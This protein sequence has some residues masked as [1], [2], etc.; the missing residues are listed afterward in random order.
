MGTSS[1]E[2]ATP[3]ADGISLC[4]VVVPAT[5]SELTL[6]GKTPAMRPV[7]IGLLTVTPT[8]SPVAEITAPTADGVYYSDQLIVFE[9]SV[10]DGED[11][12]E[13]LTVEWESSLDG[14][15]SIDDELDSEGALA[16]A[17]NLSEGEHFTLTATD[18]TPG[19]NGSDNM[20]LTVGATQYG[21]R[22]FHYGARRWSRGVFGGFG[23]L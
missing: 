23:D 9:G 7:A 16:G 3:D 19:K 14:V 8:E 15:L 11:L 5:A 20:T 17:A 21:S 12:A 1:C 13:Q 10:S 2:S 4:D 18:N 6:E 22:L